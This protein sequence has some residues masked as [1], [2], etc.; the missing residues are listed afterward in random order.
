MALW[1]NRHPDAGERIAQFAIANAQ[2]RVK[3]AAKVVRK[4][5]SGGPALPGKLADC[6]S[7]E[8]KR[9]ELFLVEGDSAGGSAKQAREKD[10][11]AIM[12]LRGKILNT[13]E[14]DSGS[15]GSSEEVHNISDR[16]RRRP[17]LGGS[18]AAA[19]SQGLHPRGRGLRRAAHRDTAV[20]AVPAALPAAGG[21]RSRVRGDAAAVSHRCRQAGASTRSMTTERD[22]M[23]KKIEK[24]NSRTKPSV[25]RFKGLG[26]MNPSQ[27][28]ET[29]IDPRT[30]R[31]VQLTIEAAGRDRQADGHAAG[32]E[33]RGRPPRVAGS[34]RATS[35]KCRSEWRTKS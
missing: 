35:P 11:Q 12:P 5:I 31:L 23:L 19:L 4:R 21:E 22:Q 7:Q 29:T 15:I 2:E 27:L 25:T 30:R 1:L 13:W 17:G 8:P 18:D 16:A 10:F 33:A 34:R 6:A 28:R 24:E 32:Q 3:A 14:L 20:R 9:S 26:E